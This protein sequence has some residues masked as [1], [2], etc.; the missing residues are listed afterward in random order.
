[1]FTENKGYVTSRRLGRTPKE[2]SSELKAPSQS[3]GKM[4]E[5]VQ[6]MLGLSQEE[7]AQLLSLLEKTDFAAVHFF[8]GNTDISFRKILPWGKLSKIIL[9][10]GA[11]DGDGNRSTSKYTVP[12]AFIRL[13]KRKSLGS[14]PILEYFGDSGN[15]SGGARW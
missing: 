10:V 14:E 9:Q 3:I 5:D 8:R 15:S 2:I 4:M 7:V 6:L 1:M 11:T 13:A 12:R